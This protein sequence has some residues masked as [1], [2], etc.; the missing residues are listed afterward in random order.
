MIHH[1]FSNVHDATVSSNLLNSDL[2]KISEW[3]LLRKMIFNPN[4]TKP[5]E[6]RSY[7]VAEPYREITRALC[8]I[9]T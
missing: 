1:F 6:E 9:V 3:A 5:V 4:P 2:F 7:S 8:L